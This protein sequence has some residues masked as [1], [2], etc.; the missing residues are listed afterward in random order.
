MFHVL[1][2]FGTFN[3]A[4]TLPGNSG[5]GIIALHGE[6]AFCGL[7]FGGAVLTRNFAHDIDQVFAG[8]DGVFSP[9]VLGG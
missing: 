3:D 2:K 9:A 4:T 7:H 5:S 8:G 6:M 1:A